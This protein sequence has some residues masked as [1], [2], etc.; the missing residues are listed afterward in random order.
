MM[1]RR[2]LLVVLAMMFFA[3]SAMADDGGSPKGV[4]SGKATK[5]YKWWYFA[6]LPAEYFLV[7]I[8]LHEGSHA[9][10]TAIDSD[11]E[12]GKF[13]PYPHLTEDGSGFYLGS[14]DIVCTG[15]ACEDKTGLAVISLAPYITDTLLFSVSDLLLSTNVVEPTS[16]SGRILFFAGMA[17]PLWDFSY[18]AGWAIDMSDAAHIATNLEIPRSA[19]MAAGM[20]VSAVGILRLWN[21]YKRAFSAPSKSHAKESSLVVAPIGSSQMLG[22]SVRG[23]F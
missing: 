1:K 20:S 22:L 15:D 2:V 10:A 21:G 4:H 13:P 23:K 6:G 14:V 12:V 16:I 9:L 18:N 17:V 8:P 5:S 3:H 11:Y 7:H 19:V